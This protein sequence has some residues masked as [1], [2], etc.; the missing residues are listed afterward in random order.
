MQE[1]GA[2]DKNNVTPHRRA[3][4]QPLAQ[5]PPLRAE[6]RYNALAN[7]PTNGLTNAPAKRCKMRLADFALSY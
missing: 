5:A 2:P 7:A 6:V 3:A 1:P 4:C